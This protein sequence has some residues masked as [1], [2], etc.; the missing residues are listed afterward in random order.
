MAKQSYPYV[1]IECGVR[2]A[3]NR[4][5]FPLDELL[6]IFRVATSAG[7]NVQ[8]CLKYALPDFQVGAVFGEPV[9]GVRVPVRPEDTQADLLWANEKVMAPVRLSMA[10]VLA[11]IETQLGLKAG[12]LCTLILEV[13][14]NGSFNMWL[15]EAENDPAPDEHTLQVQRL[16][17]ALEQA[18]LPYLDAELGNADIRKDQCVKTV[19][20]LRLLVDADPSMHIDPVEGQMRYIQDRA[21]VVYAAWT[22]TTDPLSHVEIPAGL[23]IFAPD[24][25]KDNKVYKCTESC[26]PYCHRPLPKSF[27]AYRQV[28]VGVLGGQSA[29]KTTYLAAL[30]DSLSRDAIMSEMP[31]FVSR[32]DDED[33][34]WKRFRAEPKRSEKGAQE[35][36][37]GPLWMYR[38]GYRVRKTELTRTDAAS[39]TFRVEPKNGEPVLYVLADIAGEAFTGERAV[40][41]RR[42][43]EQQK[44]LLSNCDALFMVF[45]CDPG[46]L[47]VDASDYISWMKDFTRE[48][49]IGEGVPAALLLTKAD[50]MFAGADLM[51]E[52]IV[53]RRLTCAMRGLSRTVP[54]VDRQYNVEAM[55]ALCRLTMDCADN[56]APGLTSGLRSMLRAAAGGDQSRIE[57][58]AFP[59]CAG[60]DGYVE[61]GTNADEE[62]CEARYAAARRTRYGV[63][64]PLLWLLALRDILP[65]G[66]GQN[67]FLEYDDRTRAQLQAL[68][69]EELRCPSDSDA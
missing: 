14:D 22:Y 43:A 31:F 62:A 38:S 68:L 63:L 5:F 34:Q 1:C 16:Y 17:H 56:M 37:G 35:S 9:L 53:R 2:E 54:V 60:T 18:L 8:E 55:S 51:D 13:P 20:M 46:D 28:T 12:T 58:A 26:C 4:R 11:A 27:G 50:K 65:A 52:F 47:T 61:I 32:G 23:S 30:A 3:H 67:G 59:V 57:M 33:P 48:N 64:G 49:L 21:A 29:G 10:G 36:A 39:L 25:P 41:A 24:D 40:T 15:Q 66:R 19:D 42:A 69:R 6:R 44:A 7:T 45:S